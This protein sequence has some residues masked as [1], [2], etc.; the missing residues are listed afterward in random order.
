MKLG[1][2]E[3]GSIMN[4]GPSLLPD[5]IQLKDWR[6]TQTSIETSIADDV[7]YDQ[8][9]LGKAYKYT[10]QDKQF[11]LQL[12]YFFNTN[13]DVLALRDRLASFQKQSENTNIEWEE[14]SQDTTGSYLLAHS[15]TGT[16]LL[17]TCINADG[18]NTVNREQFSDNRLKHDISLTQVFQWLIG[19]SQ[20]LDK[21][22]LWT[23]LSL[24]GVESKETARQEA[25]KILIEL[26]PR[27]SQIL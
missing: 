24:E 4:M 26:Q 23:H 22:C 16:T 11:K 1:G 27:L 10:N 7:S 13:G 20:F 15:T 18:R 12:G 21:R 2:N 14:L 19:R 9:L 17:L 5:T 6:M 25:E 8:L 3:M